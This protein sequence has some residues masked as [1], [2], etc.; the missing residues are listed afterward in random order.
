MLFLLAL[1]ARALARIALAI[2]RESSP[3]PTQIG[4]FSS[5]LDPAG[6]LPWPWNFGNGKRR[7]RTCRWTASP[8]V[9]NLTMDLS[10]EPPR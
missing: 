7:P 9:I 1:L 6:D 3:R 2:L 10:S 8:F 5:F 4:V